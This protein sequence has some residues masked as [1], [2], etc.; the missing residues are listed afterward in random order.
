MRDSPYLEPCRL[1]DVIAA[2]QVLAYYK[3]YRLDVAEWAER[4]SGD[5]SLAEGLGM[6]FHDHPEFF[7]LSTGDRGPKAALV[8]RRSFTRSYDV[9]AG[10]GISKAEAMK[11]RDDADAWSRLSRRPLTPDETAV[12]IRTAIDMHS[13]A[14][15][16]RS[17]GRWW[18][19][20][21]GAAIGFAGGIASTALGVL[22]AT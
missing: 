9:D 11:R 21:A 1:G 15:E 12:L 8:A 5:R 4:I 10:E 14:V 6:V 3:F 16:Q 20:L 18:V 22:I 19:P 17:A 2:I 13:R 7:Q